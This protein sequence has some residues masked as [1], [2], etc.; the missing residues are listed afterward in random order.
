MDE[1]IFDNEFIRKTLAKDVKYVGQVGQNV[2]QDASS[3]V[4]GWF[5]DSVPPATCLVRIPCKNL[6]PTTDEMITSWLG[7]CRQGTYNTRA[8][9]FD[10]MH[11][12][13]TAEYDMSVLATCDDLVP[14]VVWGLLD[15]REQEQWYQN[16]LTHDP[17][18]DPKHLA[19]YGPAGLRLGLL[20]QDADSMASYVRQ[21]NLIR[22]HPDHLPINYG[23]RHTI[24]QPVCKSSLTSFLKPDLSEY[25]SDVFFPMAHS[26]SAAPFHA[27]CSTWALSLIHI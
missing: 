26:V 16:T 19:V 13:Q 12:L 1:T 20:S 4:C 23:L 17:R 7:M 15:T 5:D 2:G 9:L 6:T 8:E 10:F 11:I 22:K 25:F 18:A 14:S 24:A 21:H 3:C 27:Y